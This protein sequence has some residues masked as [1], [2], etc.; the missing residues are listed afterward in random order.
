MIHASALRYLIKVAELGSVRRA[1]DALNVASSA[2]NRQVLNVERDI[3]ARLFERS[4]KGMSLTLA[5]EMMLRH[6]RETLVGYQRTIDEIA[7]IS[8]DVRGTVRIVGIGSMI[9]YAFPKA[10]A[11]ITQITHCTPVRRGAADAAGCDW[12]MNQIVSTAGTG[13]DRIVNSCRRRR[14]REENVR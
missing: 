8:G 13:F 14:N 12:G 5:G 10:M 7:S 3:G 11:A 2:V 6:A 1:A 9:E 4:A